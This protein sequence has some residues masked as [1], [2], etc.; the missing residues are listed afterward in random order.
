MN[1]KDLLRPVADAASLSAP[2]DNF[3]TA[4]AV[5]F[6]NTLSLSRAADTLAAL[7]LPRAVKML[8]QP[9][10]N[11]GGDLVAA[12]PVARAAALLGLMADDRATDIVHELDEDERAR[13]IPLLSPEA[14]KAIQQL[15]SYPAH[16]AGALMTTE[17]VSVPSDWTVGRTLQH[18]RE[19]ERT[20]ETVYAIY[21]LDPHTRALVQVV[22]MRRLIT[23]LP[24]EPILDVAQVN[25]PVTV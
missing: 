3:N 21:V 8:E 23:G 17:F 11:R 13:L 4:D 1:Q 5:E 24:E 9:E 16:T 2:L 25:P 7:P 18:I 10:L 15:L 22:T 20:R 12:M 19:V 6:L 14:R